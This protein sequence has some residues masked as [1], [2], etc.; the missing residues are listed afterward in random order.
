M[1]EISQLQ[2]TSLMILLNLLTRKVKTDIT[3]PNGALVHTINGPGSIK[4]MMNMMM[5]IMMICCCVSAR[6][7]NFLCIL[8]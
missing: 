6:V 1:M 4:S 7:W 5:I 2:L 8:W 3:N